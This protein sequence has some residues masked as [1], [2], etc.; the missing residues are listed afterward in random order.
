MQTPLRRW[1]KWQ[2][3]CCGFCRGRALREQH[4][5]QLNKQLTFICRLCLSSA[6][7]RTPLRR[8]TGLQV[9][10]SDTLCYCSKQ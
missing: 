4:R 5:I 6:Q 2:P 9:P 7:A 8:S 10:L 3:A 1:S